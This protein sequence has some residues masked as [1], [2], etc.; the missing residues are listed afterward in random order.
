MTYDDSYIEYWG[1]VYRARAQL[2]R[3][4]TFEQFLARPLYYADG[5]VGQAL[6]L[7]QLAVQRRV[8]AQC[9]NGRHP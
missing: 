3:Y 4:C 8:D 7:E 6:L 2:Q 5:H 1:E 9:H